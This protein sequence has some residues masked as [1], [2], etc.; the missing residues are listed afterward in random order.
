MKKIIFITVLLVLAVQSVNAQRTRHKQKAKTTH[1][2]KHNIK[3]KK[4]T[5]KAAPVEEETQKQTSLADNLKEHSVTI[6]SSFTPSLRDAAKINFNATALQSDTSAP[7][8]NYNIPSQNFFFSYE[9]PGLH[10][11]ALNI[12]SSTHWHNDNFVKLGFGNYTTP[13]AE[14]GISLGDG[15]INA[16]TIHAKYTS[17]VGSLPFQQFAKTGVDASGV[18]NPNNDFEVSAKVF[19]DLNSQYRYGYLPNTLQ[20]SKDSLRV[21]YTTFGGK[22]ALRN[23]ITN[24]LGVDYNPSVAI[25]SFSSNQSASEASFI[26][27]AP[28]SKLLTNNLSLKLKLNEDYTGY[29]NDLSGSSFSNNIFYIAPA[30][31][32]ET[33]TFRATAGVTPSWD[34]GAYHTLPDF[35]IEAKINNEKLLL[36]AGWIGYYNKNTY[37]TLADYNPWIENPEQLLN[38]RAGEFYAGLKGSVGSNLSYNGKLSFIQYHDLP[39]FLNDSI[40]GRYFQTLYESA[41]NDMRIHGELG[42]AITKNFSVDGSITFNVYSKLNDNAKAWGLPTT[43][44]NGT[45]R[46]MPMKTLTLKSDLFYWDGVHYLNQQKQDAIINP[47]MDWN[48]GAELSVKKNLSVWLQINNLLNDKYQRWNQYTV[49]GINVLGGIVYRF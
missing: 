16:A 17:S 36:Q 41:V 5:E 30:V 9:T 10:P 25:N 2:K 31:E 32:Y 15:I 22:I 21:R 40:T 35:S 28:F 3:N 43:E 11:L 49:L 19:F 23:I 13:Y 47:A 12:D 34:R 37:R 48:V 8:L 38:T 26:L 1:T 45:L 6:T 44:L 14:A 33:K 42:Y 46:W 29:K 7:Q 4:V 24:Y 18:F 27:D 39:L 20:L